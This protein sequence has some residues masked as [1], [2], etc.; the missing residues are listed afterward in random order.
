[1]PTR[2]WQRSFQ[3]LTTTAFLSSV[4]LTI[5]YITACDTGG[6]RSNHEPS[7]PGLETLLQERLAQRLR[8]RPN[9]EIKGR[10]TTNDG[11]PLPDVS[12][13][14]GQTTTNTDPQGDF[15]L[16]GIPYGSYVVNFD[17]PQ[18][19]FTQRVVGA[20]YEN[21]PYLSVSMMERAQPST[22]DADQLTE[23]VQGPLTL[24]IKP[25]DLVLEDTGV[26]VHG[27]VDIIATNIE[28]G[29]KGHIEASP[30]PLE[31][32]RANGQIT[33]LASLGMF[34]VELLQK[35]Q[36]VQVRQGGAVALRM[37]VPMIA[38][39]TQV[40]SVPLWHHDRNLGIWVE[41]SG[42][43]ARAQSL[44][45]GGLIEFSAALPHFSS[46]NFDG[47]NPSVCVYAM[48][49]NVLGFRTVS[50]ISGTTT[51]DNLWS[52]TG[53]CTLG[54]GCVANAPSGWF[55]T[56]NVSFKFQALIPTN[57]GN[58]W[59]DAPMVMTNKISV[60][61]FGDDVLAYA[62][63]EGS[64][65][66]SYCGS[67][68]PNINAE[69]PIVAT[70]AYQYWH[71]QSIAGTLLAVPLEPADLNSNGDVNDDMTCPGGATPT[72]STPKDPGFSRMTMNALS[73]SNF[74]DVDRDGK[75]DATDPC[76]L[77][78]NNGSCATGCYVSPSDPNRASFDFDLDTID[79]LCDNK[80]SIYNPTQN[81]GL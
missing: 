45:T 38:G 13:S 47:P 60:P 48:Y 62:Q 41:A 53:E 28:P 51:E 76:P 39:I 70:G 63:I 14:I 1:M 74:K 69:G 19:V 71:D 32:L 56:A 54:R 25:G 31:G 4:I 29:K 12:V 67:S 34:E 50:T 9:T 46:W 79:D 77:R 18:Y 15:V 59:C 49:A 30:A 16:S 33:A 57:M 42:M 11:I 21:S 2:F 68:M 17:H 10:V 6:D 5:T 27:N 55:D 7:Q 75:N 40:S 36:R 8:E 43:E 61:L 37:R 20:Q 66:S 44:S 80:V 26:P 23:F 3:Y 35:G 73:T 81:N 78:S 64:Q 52:M 24:V 22:I 65:P 72:T 58:L